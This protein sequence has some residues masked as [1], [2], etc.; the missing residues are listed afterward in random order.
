VFSKEKENDMKYGLIDINGKI[1]LKPKNIF[2]NIT[3]F[4]E[5]LAVIKT[6]FDKYGFIDKQGKTIVKPIYDETGIFSEGFAV[7]CQDE[8]YGYINRRG[9]V[10]I[11][12]QYDE[13]KN[14][15][16]GLAAVKQNDEWFYI[17]YPENPIYSSD[18][19]FNY[20]NKFSI[21]ESIIEDYIEDI[22]RLYEDNEEDVDIY[23]IIDEDIFINKFKDLDINSKNE[24]G[25]SIIIEVIRY[26][27][28]EIFIPLLKKA[29]CDL[30]IQNNDG[31]T[32]LTIAKRNNRIDLEKLL[33]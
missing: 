6:D 8:K 21:L 10:V 3:A 14:F 29:G 24:K 26:P 31:D 4:S 32:A 16:E 17:P 19:S 18:T 28:S 5:G 1:I 15:F 2:D 22:D 12:P 27:Y 9:K 33:S 11:K 20:E 23:N 25:N 13:A 7:I 30:N